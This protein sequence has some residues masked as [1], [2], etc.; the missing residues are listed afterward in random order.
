MAIGHRI[1][2]ATLLTCVLITL[3]ARGQLRFSLPEVDLS[4]LDPGNSDSA[5]RQDLRNLDRS[6]LD[7]ISNGPRAGRDY[8]KVYLQNHTSETIWA[9]VRVIPFEVSD[10]RTSETKEYTS[11][12]SSPWRTMGWYKLAP[13][14]RSHIVNTNN[15]IVYTYAKTQSG[16]R[17]AGTHPVD[18]RNNNSSETLMFS[19]RYVGL[20]VPH[21]HTFGFSPRLENDM[22]TERI[23]YTIRN[24]SGREVQF[25]LPSGRKYALGPGQSGD[26]TNSGSAD[27]L[28]IRILNTGRDYPL[29]SGQHR[30]WWMSKSQRVG[31][32]L[33]SRK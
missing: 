22:P 13:G 19:K 33:N 28:R 9:A 1:A 32:D 29:T 2:T 24:D 4:D 16:R 14:E 30:L 8:T 18:I 3:P 7:A 15:V 10:G 21:E 5:I 31:F 17:W 25:L 6:I 27:E 11:N 26:Y 23:K 12:S 20:S